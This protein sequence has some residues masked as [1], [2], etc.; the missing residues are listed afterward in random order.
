MKCVK[1]VISALLLACCATTFAQ[2]GTTMKLWPNAPEVVSSDEKDE[3]EVT[4]YLPNAKKATGRAVVCCPGGGYSHLA[5][6]HEGHQWAA[7]F[8]TQGIAPS[9]FY[10]RY[11]F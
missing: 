4:V 2:K 6:D 5:M 10:H 1:K 8:N 3:A 11:P 9:G 7:F